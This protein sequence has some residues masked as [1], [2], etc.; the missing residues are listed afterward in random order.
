MVP[1][2]A[3]QEEPV[4]DYGDFPAGSPVTEMGR[5]C[6]DTS[7]GGHDVLCQRLDNGRWLVRFI[8]PYVHIDVHTDD[9]LFP[10]SVELETDE[11]GRY[12]GSAEEISGRTGEISFIEGTRTQLTFHDFEVSP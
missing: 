3:Q 10:D 7:D 8:Y 2:H 12:A 9:I 11:W 6:Q 1:N 5:W 4:E